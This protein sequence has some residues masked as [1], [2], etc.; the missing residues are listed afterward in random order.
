MTNIKEL[1]KTIKNRRTLFN[2]TQAD[3]AELT[4]VSDRT[5]RSIEAGEGGI[6]LQS[7]LNVLDVLGLEIKLQIKTVSGAASNGLLQ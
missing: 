7:W 5:I 3:L 1:A 6:A 4:N 2:Y